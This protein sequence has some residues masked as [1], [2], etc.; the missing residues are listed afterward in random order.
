MI[1]ILLAIV[2]G[3]ILSLYAYQIGLYLLEKIFRVKFK[4]ELSFSE[5]YWISK[6]TQLF[7]AVIFLGV[8][9]LVGHF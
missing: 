9:I 7:I 4:K 3:G 1:A 2:L 5:K 6:G 8:L